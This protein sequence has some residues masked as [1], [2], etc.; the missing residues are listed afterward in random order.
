MALYMQLPSNLSFLDMFIK[1]S[2]EGVKGTANFKLDEVS[3]LLI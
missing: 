1:T 3:R 2:N